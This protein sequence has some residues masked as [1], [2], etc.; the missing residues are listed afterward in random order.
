MF[1]LKMHGLIIFL[2]AT[3][4]A[5]S[6]KAAPPTQSTLCRNICLDAVADSPL[7]SETLGEGASDTANCLWFADGHNAYFANFDSVRLS[8]LS[9]RSYTYSSSP[10]K[11]NVIPS[12]E[13]SN[14]V[15]NIKAQKQCVIVASGWQWAQ[16]QVCI[17]DSVTSRILED[18][19]LVPLGAANTPLAC[20]AACDAMGFSFAGVEFATEC[21]CGTGFTA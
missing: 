13:S 1:N 6:T 12:S 3:L 11:G 20:T 21:H 18:D 9:L 8:P 14:I 16:A 15:F 10:Q 17:E 2:T 7:L 5:S 4:V 19:T